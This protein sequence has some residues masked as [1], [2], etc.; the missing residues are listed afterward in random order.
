[1]GRYLRSVVIF[2]QPKKRNY[3]IH[4]YLGFENIPIKDAIQRSW[5]D[6]LR[7]SSIHQVKGE[8]VRVRRDED[9][10][11]ISVVP[12]TMGLNK[13]NR[14]KKTLKK[15]FQARYLII[16]TGIDQIKPDITNF[17]KFLGNGIWHCPHCDG[18]STANKKLI[19]IASQNNPEKAIQYAKIFLGWTNDITLFLQKTITDSIT[20]NNMLTD[21]QIKETVKLGIRVVKDDR[22]VKITEDPETHKLRGVLTEKKVFFKSDI[23]FYHMGTLRNNKIPIQLGCKLYKGYLKVNEKQQTSLSKVYAVGDIDTDRHYAVLA[24]ASGAV[25]AQ[26]I[27]EELLKESLYKK[28]NSS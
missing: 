11:L 16:A 22:I 26:N 21:D 17:D 12:S 15:E 28:K 23:L 1:L 8:T 25:A 14:T 9:L 13:E 4:G 20:S 18:F 2:D 7:Y 5:Q 19:I 6:V 3:N 27:Y 24:S 10:F